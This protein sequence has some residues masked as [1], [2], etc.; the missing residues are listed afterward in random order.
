MAPDSLGEQLRRVG[1]LTGFA[2]VV[3]CALF[4]FA[5]LRALAPLG[6][7]S[8]TPEV[9][10]ALAPTATTPITPVTPSAAAAG[11][12]GPNPGE[13]QRLEQ[14]IAAATGQQNTREATLLRQELAAERRGVVVTGAPV[15]VP[16][17]PAG[18]PTVEPTNQNGSTPVSKPPPPKP[19]PHTNDGGAL[20]G[21]TPG[22]KSQ[23]SGKKPG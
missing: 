13:E 11:V 14:E 18:S 4:T 19:T 23:G 3:A 16:P 9:H 21:G 1:P 6:H 20:A 15:I 22:G 7:D 12:I 5:G 10:N 2:L 8:S 17:H